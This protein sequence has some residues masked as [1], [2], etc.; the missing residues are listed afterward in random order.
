MERAHDEQQRLL[1]RQIERLEAAA[2]AGSSASSS[3]LAM[4][5]SELTAVEGERTMLQQQL[6]VSACTGRAPRPFFSPLRV[7]LVFG[8]A[9][10]TAPCARHAPCR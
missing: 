10:G 1:K 5:R 8:H 2:A 3:E 6:Q 4:L 7:Y 9:V